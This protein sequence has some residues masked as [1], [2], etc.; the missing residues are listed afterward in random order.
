MAQKVERR[1]SHYVLLPRQKVSNLKLVTTSSF[2][3]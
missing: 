3:N 1:V 2:Q